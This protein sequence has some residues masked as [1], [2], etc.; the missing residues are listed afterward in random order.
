VG[1]FVNHRKDGSIVYIGAMISS[2]LDED[3]MPAYFMAFEEDITRRKLLEI[4]VEQANQQIQ[5]NKD[6]LVRFKDQ[7]QEQR[8]QDRLT[9]L[10]NRLT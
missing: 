6:E 2:L 3:G 5:T 1:E 8:W 10:C 7:L 9:V 4:E